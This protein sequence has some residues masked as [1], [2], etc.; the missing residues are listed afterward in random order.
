MK[1]EPSQLSASELAPL[2]ASGR[3][4][5]EAVA[6]SCLER[7]SL[8]DGELR[9]WAFVA[10]DAVIEQARALDRAGP[11]GPLF[12][13]PVGVKDVILTRDMPTQYNSQIY[14]GFHPRI[15]AACVATLRAAGALIFGKVDTVEFAAT[16]RPAPTRNPHHPAHTPG[17]SSSGSAAAV[18]DFH[19]P[20]ALGTQ[21]GGSMIRPASY[22]GVYGFKPTWNLVS[23]EGA[24]MFSATLD[25]IG[26]FGRS[27]ADLALML[28]VFDPESA[29]PLAL[30][31]ARVAL[32]RSPVWRQADADTRAAFEGAAERL[33]LAGAEVVELTLP[34]P[35]E[36]LPALQLLIMRAEARGTFLA[37]H[38]MHAAE[39]H[40]SLNAMVENAHGIS[41][42]QLCEAYDTAAACRAAF[43]RIAAA[44]DVVLTP[45]TVGCAPAGLEQTGP[46]TF[47]GI[48]SLLQVPVANV[49]GFT[50]AGGLPVG[51]SVTGPRFADARVLA[52]AQAL[53]ALFEPLSI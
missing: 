21:T 29:P 46:L 31:G 6:R 13:I 2:L 52:A 32:C 8:R 12:G 28:R 48:W 16:G 15:D 34:A 30:A 47:N 53:G 41:R 17:G 44:Y 1:T 45:S 38:R 37:E 26:W 23:P 43:D 33:R 51:L 3:L 7:V 49:P 25:T 40:A 11:R 4:T 14:R 19:V 27:A 50:G 42:A 20:L 22:C 10:P 36:R 5:A 18:A 9:A 35:F 24:K 39:L